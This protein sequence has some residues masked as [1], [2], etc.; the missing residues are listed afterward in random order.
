[1]NLADQIVVFVIGPVLLGVWLFVEMLHVRMRRKLERERR[2][3]RQARAALLRDCVAQEE[4]RLRET[5]GR[6]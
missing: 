5:G 3:H 6:T 4:A 2:A 1:M